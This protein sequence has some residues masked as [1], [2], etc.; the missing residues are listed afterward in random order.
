M[1]ACVPVALFFSN[2]RVGDDGFPSLS[3]TPFY[4]GWLTFL[5]RPL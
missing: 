3:Y 4:F 5:R 2:V 1:F